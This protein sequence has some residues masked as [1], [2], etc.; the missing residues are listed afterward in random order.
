MAQ[1][2]IVRRPRRWDQPFGHAPLS[3]RDVAQLRRLPLFSEVDGDDFPTDLPLD[4]LLA[5]DT[6]VL[7]AS[8]GDVV[9]QRG[10]YG[11][12]LFLVLRGSVERLSPFLKTNDVPQEIASEKKTWLQIKQVWKQPNPTGPASRPTGQQ[13][14]DIVAAHE[15][16]GVTE[17]MTRSPRSHT[18]VVAEDQTELLE[19]RWAALRDLRDWSASFQAV[20]DRH[21]RERSLRS[22]LRSWLQL[23]DINDDTL[24]TL[25]G[26]CRV[27]TY[28]DFSWSH[29]FQR[30]RQDDDA[31]SAILNSEPMIVE[32]GHYLDDILLLQAGFARLSQPFGNG[33]RTTGYL[34]AGETFG[35]DEIAASRLSIDAPRAPYSLRAM[36]FANMIRIP[37]PV[38][39]PFVETSSASRSEN[40][41]RSRPS[42][43]E[44]S[45]LPQPMMDFF[46]DNR[47]VNGTRAMAI[48]T[49][50]CVDCDDCVRA[51]A[52][53]HAGFP[54]FVRHGPTHGNLMIAN[55]CMHCVDPVCL[56]GCPTGAI[57]RVADG[58]GVVIDDASCVGCA[59]C[60]SNCPYGNIRMEAVRDANGTRHIDTDGSQILR[61]TKCDF[62]AGQTNGP[63]CQ[64]ACPHGALIRIDMSDTGT[65]NDW[66][67]RP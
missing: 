64:R 42:A 48:D 7:R 67:A 37:G 2:R 58:G 61:A 21:Y 63:A 35:H 44:S 10:S 53:T 38:A 45:N 26:F 47:F 23:A 55:A 16:F 59:T 22:G 8:K 5:N 29:T 34:K 19:L 65:L 14:Q 24:E 62:C 54:R 25:A 32:Q 50:R 4:H 1:A 15:V 41:Q 12:S 9:F 33:E 51:C 36:G 57:Q 40:L 31:R 3:A 49:T 27:E 39:E 28:G 66:I 56:I 43:D 13:S 11:N 18:M 30:A 52:A 46:V 60:A 17:A 20:I 6:R